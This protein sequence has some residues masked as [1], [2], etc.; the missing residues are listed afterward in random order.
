MPTVV[1]PDTV[2]SGLPDGIGWYH[3][4]IKSVGPELTMKFQD[5]LGAPW[6]DPLLHRT[7][8][9]LIRAEGGNRVDDRHLESPSG[10]HHRFSV[11]V[12]AKHPATADEWLA[13]L[14]GI[15]RQAE[16]VNFE[17]P[18]GAPGLVGGLLGPQPHLHP[19][20][21]EALRRRDRRCVRGARLQRGAGL[22]PAALHH[23][24]RGTRGL[25]DQIQ[26]LDLR[27][28]LAGQAR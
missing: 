27:H 16:A 26:R 20:R 23:G 25:P 1:E 11:Y 24:L 15:A 6:K 3:R 14:R 22:Q 4:N 19:R 2:L 17:A 9:A 12:L 7:F 21:E 13:E 28:A 10:L 8:G 18:Q 5:L